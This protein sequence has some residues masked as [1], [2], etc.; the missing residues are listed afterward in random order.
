MKVTTTR[1]IATLLYNVVACGLAAYAAYRVFPRVQLAGHAAILGAS[2][3][4]IA[5]LSAIAGQVFGKLDKLLQDSE[6]Y[7]ATR[8]RRIYAY[9]HASRRRLVILLF[10]AAAFGVLNTGLAFLLPRVAE[11]V[12]TALRYAVAVGY[13]GVMSILLFAMRLTHAYLSLDR[14]RLNLFT[15]IQNEEQRDK[16]LLELRPSALT[17]FPKREGGAGGTGVPMES[18][19]E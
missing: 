7:D 17:A 11:P 10:I 2:A 14:F 15:A 1:Q 16:A 3:A 6:K 18:V 12:E 13:A 9:V 8:V 19:R 4:L 5:I